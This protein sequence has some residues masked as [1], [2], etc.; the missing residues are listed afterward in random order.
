M[1]TYWNTNTNI[2]QK[3]TTGINFLSDNDIAAIND[4]K[5]WSSSVAEAISKLTAKKDNTTTTSE[6]IK[7]G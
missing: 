6:G 5:K 7:V 2:N 1:D 3:S 4:N